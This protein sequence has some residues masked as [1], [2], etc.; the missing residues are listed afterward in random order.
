[1][2]FTVPVNISTDAIKS[3][4]DVGTIRS[5]AIYS[6]FELNGNDFGSDARRIDWSHSIGAYPEYFNGKIA[7][8]IVL[9][10]PYETVQDLVDSLPV[11]T[12]QEVTQYEQRNIESE[13]Q[14]TENYDT[15]NGNIEGEETHLNAMTDLT[16]LPTSIVDSEQLEV[17]KVETALASNTIPT[18][19]H[20]TSGQPTNN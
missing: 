12:Q 10:E 3:C 4:F 13:L 14:L 5:D 20:D 9:A 1:L 15:A 18:V 16:Y 8:Q 17:H 2:T 19:S 11:V 6:I 7:L